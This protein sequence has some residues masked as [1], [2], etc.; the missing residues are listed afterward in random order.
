M[1]KNLTRSSSGVEWSS[2]SS[3]TRWLNSS[4][5]NSRLRKWAGPNVVTAVAI[6]RNRKS[7]VTAGQM[8]S[9][10]CVTS[11]V[12]LSAVV[13]GEWPRPSE[14]AHSEAL[15]GASSG[16][17]MQGAR[18]HFGPATAHDWGSAGLR[19][20]RYGGAPRMAPDRRPTG[21][22]PMRLVRGARRIWTL[23]APA[24]SVQIPFRSGRRDGNAAN[25]TEA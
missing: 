5:L 10:N 11:P 2:A 25:D 21:A 17:W 12:V 22:V 8:T 23:Q 13:L 3:S 24:G 19:P 14:S 7:T 6:I 16:G 9:Y 15:E 4:Q 18:R 20:G 1:Q